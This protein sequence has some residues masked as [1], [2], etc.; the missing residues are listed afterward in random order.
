MN[1]DLGESTF[2]LFVLYKVNRLFYLLTQVIVFS[3]GKHLDLKTLKMRR[4]MNPFISPDRMEDHLVWVH[5]I[6]TA[7]GQIL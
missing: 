2:S 5:R 3:K 1:K 4:I 7:G 6:H